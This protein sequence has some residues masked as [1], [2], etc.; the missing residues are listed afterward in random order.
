M[1]DL[2]PIFSDLLKSHNARLA[3]PSLSLQN[4]DEFLKEAYRIVS[5]MCPFHSIP[6][7]SHLKPNIS[8]HSHRHPERRDSLTHLLSPHHPPTLPLNRP[9]S[10]PK[11]PL[12]PRPIQVPNRPPTRRNRRPNKTTATRTQCQ[13]TES[14]RCR[15]DPSKHPNGHRTQ[16]VRAIRIRRTGL[17]GSG[18]SRTDEVV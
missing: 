11:P 15:A 14:S 9:S 8:N 1:T 13:H 12:L 10:P 6:F 2:T 16:E 17:L 7:H 18:W 5:A 4:V 3:K